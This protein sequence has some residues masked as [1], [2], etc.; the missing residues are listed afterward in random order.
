MDLQVGFQQETGG[1]QNFALV[2][3]ERASPAADVL[4]INTIAYWKRQFLNLDRFTGVFQ[5]VDRRGDHRDAELPELGQPGLV[6]SQL[7]TAVPSPVAAVEQ[8]GSPLAGGQCT[9]RL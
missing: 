2:F 4:I 9:Q 5:R 1:M 7:L 3:D 6:V 8:H